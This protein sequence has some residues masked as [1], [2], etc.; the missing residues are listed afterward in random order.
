MASTQPDQR[1]LPELLGELAGETRSLVKKEL[2]LARAELSAKAE[3]AKAALM[4][5]FSG[6]ALM[7]S[8]ILI[9]LLGAVYGLGLSM[10]MWVAALIVGS[11]ASI[12]GVLLLKAGVPEAKPEKTETEKSIRESAQAI[13]EQLS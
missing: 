13:K 8:G 6:L 10:P 7:F 9:L 5:A 2:E 11:I 3:A 4:A 12:G 1:S